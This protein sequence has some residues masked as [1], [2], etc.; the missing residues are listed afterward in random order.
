[1]PERPEPLALVSQLDSRPRATLGQHKQGVPRG[2]A[3]LVLSTAA[4]AQD[5]PQWKNPCPGRGWK[6]LPKFLWRK[7]QGAR[8]ERRGK[9]DVASLQAEAPVRPHRSPRIRPSSICISSELEEGR[10]GGGGGRPQQV[11]CAHQFE[12]ILVL[13]PTDVCNATLR[14]ASNV[15]PPPTHT[16]MDLCP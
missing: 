3:R 1:M 7:P 16:P 13:C 10:A 14:Q 4:A 9:W 6:C 8:E 2:P 5:A 12:A 11:S 15:S